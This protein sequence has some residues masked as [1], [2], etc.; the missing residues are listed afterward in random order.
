M[1][2][3]NQ[4]RPQQSKKAGIYT[5]VAA[6]Q[7]GGQAQQQMLTDDLIVLA[8]SLG[9]TDDSIVMFDDSGKPGNTFSKREGLQKL[10]RAIEQDEI[11]D[12]IVH[13]EARLFR[14]SD[15]VTVNTFLQAC[16]EHNARV[17]TP[18]TTYDFGQSENGDKVR[19]RYACLATA[20][21]AKSE[22]YARVSDPHKSEM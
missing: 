18:L 16:E 10:L 8:K 9:W 21:F 19:F 15:G 5:R 22:I 1:T 13:D 14:G 2:T 3:H 11:S 7:A 4:N 20:D 17:I 6:P 12:I